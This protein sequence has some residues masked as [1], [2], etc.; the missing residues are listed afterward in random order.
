MKNKSCGIQKSDCDETKI[1]D[2]IGL[3]LIYITLRGK[4]TQKL[5]LI[6][7]LLI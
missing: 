6:K 4:K 7:L 3:F 5:F 1:Q 2:E